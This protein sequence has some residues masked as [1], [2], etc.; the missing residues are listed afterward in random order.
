MTLARAS[1]VPRRPCAYRWTALRDPRNPGPVS[2]R[3]DHQRRIDELRLARRDSHGGHASCPRGGNPKGTWPLA[4]T[5][6]DRIPPRLSLARGLG[7]QASGPVRTCTASAATPA[8]NIP[9]T[10]MRLL[11]GRSADIQR[12]QDLVSAYRVVCLTGARQGL[13]RRHLRWRSRAASSTGLTTGYGSSSSHRW[14]IRTLSHR[15]SL[16]YLGSASNPEQ[17]P[18]TRWPRRSPA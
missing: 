14:W 17:S 3:S 11:V 4:D 9:A 1:F 2:G 13:G 8:S 12:L 10:T 5:A 16:A 7:A 6:E 15:R 18:L